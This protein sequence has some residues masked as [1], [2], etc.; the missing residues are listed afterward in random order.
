MITVEK[1]R[2]D[3]EGDQMVFSLMGDYT[4]KISEV[5]DTEN[6]VKFPTPNQL[7]KDVLSMM[8]KTKRAVCL[9]DLVD[10][11]VLGGVHKKRGLEY[12]LKRLSGFNVIE[13]C[14]PPA[15]IAKRKG[16][17]PVYYRATGEYEPKVF[18]RRSRACGESLNSVGEDN[19]PSPGT[20]LKHTEPSEK[21]NFGNKTDAPDLISE[22]AVFR[23]PSVVKNPSSASEVPIS[24]KSHVLKGDDPWKA[25]D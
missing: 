14:D 12:V 21:E 15:E 18:S 22:K 3:R 19:L 10:D 7:M 9:R 25:W 16:R 13:Q 1:S 2:D 23:K 6:T 4:Y 17:K 20:D 11:E 8:R 24:D 5:P